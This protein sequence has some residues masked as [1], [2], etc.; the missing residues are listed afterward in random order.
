L[1]DL[2]RT[3]AILADLVAFPTVSADSNLHL[4]AYASDLLSSAGARLSVSL[5]PFTLTERD[6]KLYGRGTCDMKGF[7]AASLAMA[8][9]FA[10]ARLTRPLHFA[11]TYDEEVGC[12]G[13]QAL[14]AELAETG[15]KP[16]VAIVG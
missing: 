15:I 9:S 5:D 13:G 16:S 7:I 6:G 8:P 11:L 1:S 14:V 3:R 12:L 10:A 2:A 4:I